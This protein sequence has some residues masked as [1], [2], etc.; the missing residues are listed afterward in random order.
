MEQTKTGLAAG[1]AGSQPNEQTVTNVQ[2]SKLKQ[3]R[4]MAVMNATDIEAL[5]PSYG[6]EKVPVCV[7]FHQER[8]KPLN[9]TYQVEAEEV[10][11]DK[12][13]E[14]KTERK[15]KIVNGRKVITH[16][17]VLTGKMILV[18]K[19]FKVGEVQDNRRKDVIFEAS[20]G[21]D[22]RKQLGEAFNQLQ[23]D[24]EAG[25]HPFT[26]DTLN[27]TLKIG[28]AVLSTKT[29]MEGGVK[30]SRVFYKGQFKRELYHEYFCRPLFNQ[31]KDVESGAKNKPL[32][33]DTAI[34]NAI[35]LTSK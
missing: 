27:V 33:I 8:M 35:G 9:E 14:V 17:P 31:L 18:K 13:G 30:V 1:S 12:D 10:E 6:G 19:R 20:N 32:E 11:K 24:L 26:R 4:A 3:A 28:S 16:V 5:L 29:I 15:E 34:L 7:S 23:K 25:R 22:L 2:T 21:T